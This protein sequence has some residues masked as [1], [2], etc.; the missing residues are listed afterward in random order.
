[1]VLDRGIEFEDSAN[2]HGSTLDAVLYAAKHPI[3]HSMYEENG[4]T[5]VKFIGRNHG[6]VLVPYIE[7]MMWIEKSGRMHVFH[8]NAL[9]GGFIE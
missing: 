6:D 9:Q 7:V 5:Y 1:M 3:E 8:V 4:R 2:K